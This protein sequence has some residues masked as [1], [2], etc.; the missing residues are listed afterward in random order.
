MG[1]QRA[2]QSSQILKYLIPGKE[3]LLDLR[4]CECRA[5][6]NVPKEHELYI[7]SEPL[8]AAKHTSRTPKLLHI[9]NNFTSLL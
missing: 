7:Q 1:L 8:I 2:Y 9:A 6:Y 3:I 4:Y 5:M